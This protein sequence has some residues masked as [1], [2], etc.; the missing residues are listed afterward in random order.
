MRRHGATSGS[1]S[2]T[3]TLTKTNPY[4]HKVLTNGSFLNLN[5]NLNQ[6][7]VVGPL[8]SSG[9]DDVSNSSR[10]TTSTEDTNSDSGNETHGIKHSSNSNSNSNHHI[11]N[12]Q[13]NLRR[14]KSSN[15][16]HHKRFAYQNPPDLLPPPDGFDNSIIQQQ[17]QH[18]QQ[19][20]QQQEAAPYTIDTGTAKAII[21]T[22]S[23]HLFSRSTNYHSFGRGAKKG[24]SSAGVAL[25]AANTVN[26][27]TSK[28][29]YPS[30]V[31]ENLFT[32]DPTNFEQD[33]LDNSANNYYADQRNMT[34]VVPP[35]SSNVNK[36]NNTNT[37]PRVKTRTESVV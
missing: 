3:H 26:N 16:N 35:N 37:A 11:Q 2:Q 32:R 7:D 14:S 21:D 4:R 18:L 33:S 24:S 28:S 1:N 12:H 15:N 36:P 20:L 25:T 27:N 30:S 22:Y 8:H 5:L 6:Q 29:K 9:S 13:Q 10:P 17:Q 34:V 19:Q 23:G 31:V